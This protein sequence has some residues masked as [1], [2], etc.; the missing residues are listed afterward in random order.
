VRGCPDVRAEEAEELLRRLDGVEVEVHNH[1][2]RVVDRPQDALPPDPGARMPG[3]ARQA[4][5]SGWPR[6]SS[7]GAGADGPLR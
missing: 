1:I 6:R 7:A 3:R 2:S 4:V 5:R